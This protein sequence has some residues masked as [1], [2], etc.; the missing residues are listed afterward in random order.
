MKIMHVIDSMGRGGAE[1]LLVEQIRL[2]A[3]DVESWVVAVNRG[4]A[5][6]DA[7][8][9][10]GAKVLVLDKGK[11]RWECIRRLAR[12]MREAGIDVVNGHNP[13]GGLYA[14]LASIEARGTVVFRTEHSVHYRGRHSVVYPCWK[15]APPLSRDA[16]CAGARRSWKVTFAACPGRRG[17]SSP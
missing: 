3:P 2:A 6:L 14:A 8:R 7:A 9:T 17:A 12:L 1:W 13:V 11:R 15:L 4:G 5:A 16:W 10:H